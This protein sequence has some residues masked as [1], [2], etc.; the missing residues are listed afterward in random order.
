MIRI[1]VGPRLLK[2]ARRLGPAVRQEAE[3][4]LTQLARE[5]GNPHAHRGLG[6]RKIGRRSY[7]VRLSRQLRLVL[8]LHE[9]RLLAYDILSHDGVVAW[10]KSSQ[11]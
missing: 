10:L 4:R 1:E 7:E 9:D 6:L 11:G 3:E 8:V 2:T 5:F